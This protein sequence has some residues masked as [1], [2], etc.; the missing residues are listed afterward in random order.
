MYCIP[1]NEQVRKFYILVN[2]SSTL[3]SSWAEGER[4]TTRLTGDP[5]CVEKL[6]RNRRGKLASLGQLAPYP[7]TPSP[8]GVATQAKPKPEAR[9]LKAD[10]MPAIGSDL[11]DAG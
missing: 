10:E 1:V 6:V 11:G 9:S 7:K 2:A 8:G 3:C 5:G 4:E